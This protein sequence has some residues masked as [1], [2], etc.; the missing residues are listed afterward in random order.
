[1][2]KLLGVRYKNIYYW[3]RCYY[4]SAFEFRL[5]I[6]SIEYFLWKE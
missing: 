1:M 6:R 3:I 5:F 4:C 2:K